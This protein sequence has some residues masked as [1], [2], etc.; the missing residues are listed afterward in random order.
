MPTYNCV[1]TRQSSLLRYAWVLCT[2]LLSGSL[3]S[4]TQGV[5]GTWVE[6]GV[7][8]SRPPAELHLNQRYAECAILYFAPNHDFALIYG[9][10]IKAPQSEGLSHGDGGVVY[11]GTWTAKDAILEIHYQLVSRTV[12]KANESL[13]GPVQAGEVKIRDRALLFANKRFNRH[14]LLDDELRSTLQGEQSR[15]SR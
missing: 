11:L 7:K 15:L 10:V 4:Q 8:W 2:I 6:T 3:E 9:T 13:P 14:A 12:Q 1:V 5:T